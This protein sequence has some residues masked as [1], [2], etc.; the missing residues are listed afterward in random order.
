MYVRISAAAKREPELQIRAFGFG[1]IARE[2][3]FYPRRY[4]QADAFFARFRKT[5]CAACEEKGFIPL[6]V[7]E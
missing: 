6:R 1:G 4:F 2:I 3:P 7:P 5:L